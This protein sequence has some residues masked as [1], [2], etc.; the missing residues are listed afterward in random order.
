M[1]FNVYAKNSKK[2]SQS[3]CSGLKKTVKR[4]Q[5]IIIISQSLNSFPFKSV[6]MEITLIVG[7][8]LLE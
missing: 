6:L 1:D 2:V 4:I 7:G 3:D 5:V 8:C